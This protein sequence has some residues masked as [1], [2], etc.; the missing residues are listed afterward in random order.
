MKLL[1][2]YLKIAK[3]MDNKNERI[4]LPGGYYTD[5]ANQFI[6][7]I[8]TDKYGAPFIV[9]KFTNV[10]AMK[11]FADTMNAEIHEAELRGARKM[12][13]VV[14]QKILET[15]KSGVSGR[16]IIRVL[17]STK[18]DEVIKWESTQ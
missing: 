8:M 7:A 2:S 6:S 10:P 16:D 3:T 18:P 1:T 12:Q 15:W 17:E 14:V 11:D 13:H 4:E 5:M 9:S